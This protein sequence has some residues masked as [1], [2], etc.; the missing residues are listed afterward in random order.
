MMA[1]NKL[2]IR[3]EEAPGTAPGSVELMWSADARQAFVSV[4]EGTDESVTIITPL[5]ALRLAAELLRFAAAALEGP[6]P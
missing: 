3:Q 5:Q 2:K 4:A 1:A 6:Q